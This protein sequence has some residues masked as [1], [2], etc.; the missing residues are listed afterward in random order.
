MSDPRNFDLAKIKPGS[1]EWAVFVSARMLA[2][3]MENAAIAR[4]EPTTSPEEQ[5][6]WDRRA[7]ESLG[8]YRRTKEAWHADEWRDARAEGGEA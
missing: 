1:L 8:S 7:V 2:D 4:E 6:E 3:D 5:S